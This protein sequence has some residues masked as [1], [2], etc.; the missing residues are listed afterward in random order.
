MNSGESSSSATTSPV[1]SFS[2]FFRQVVSPARKSPT[3]FSAPLACGTWDDNIHEQVFNY[4]DEN[5]DG[6]IS[7]EELKNKLREVGG[8]E[9]RLSDEEAEIAVRSSDADGDGMLGLDDFKKM[10]KEGEEEELREAFVMYCR[11]STYRDRE[12]GVIT[13]KSL[14]RMMKRLGQSTTVNDCKTMIG[15]FDVN[16]DGVLD[17]EEFRTMMS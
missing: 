13:A 9:H 15:R 12:G 1:T 6:K 14:K 10:M 2:R 4:F 8:E 17:F 16:G 3:S 5:G 7:A 11:K